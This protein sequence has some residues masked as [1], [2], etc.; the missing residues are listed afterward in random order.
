MNNPNEQ[1]NGPLDD[2]KVID[3]DINDIDE[4]LT[5]LDAFKEFEREMRGDNITFG[6][7]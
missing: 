4:A 7:F 5:Q 2:F 6:D 3:P 1:P